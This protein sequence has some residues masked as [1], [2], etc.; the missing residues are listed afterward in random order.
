MIF[1]A[2]RF[3]EIRA[4]GKTPLW[5]ASHLSSPI[6]ICF[7]LQRGVSSKYRYRLWRRRFWYENVGRSLYAKFDPGSTFGRFGG[8]YLGL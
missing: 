5:M 8:F 7:F 3:S 6:R 1:L 2:G 4:F